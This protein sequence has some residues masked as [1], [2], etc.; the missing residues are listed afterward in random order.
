MKRF[1]PFLIDLYIVKKFLGTFFFALSL[2]I[3]IAVI[4]DF[5]EKID[6]FLEKQAPLK[7]IIVDYY[8]NFIPYF[9]VLF[10]SLFVFI[11]VLFFT[12]KMAGNSEIIAI[13]SS[14]V[15]LRRLLYPYFV[16]SVIIASLSYYLTNYVIP[17]NTYSRLLFEDVY[18]HSSPV[19]YSETNIHRQLQPGQFIYMEGFS[20]LSDIGRRFSIEQYR[21]DTL[22]SKINA[23]IVRWDSA[24]NKWTMLNYYRRDFISGKEKVTTGL[25]CD[26]TLN[27]HPR[28]FKQRENIIETMD[29]PRLDR[30]IENQKLQGSP[31]EWLLI[32]KH[33]RMAYPFSTIIL[34]VIAVCVSS[35]KVRGGIGMHMGLG[36]MISFSYILFMQFA[37]QFAIGGSI[38]PQ[39]A[40]WI[41]NLLYAAIALFLFYKTPQ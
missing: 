13:F 40:V 28:D 35:R 8:L 21:G 14:G 27:M 41:P 22:V 9:A 34:T 36:L 20:T 29:K 30:Y 17:H 19:Y 25:M 1:R 26:T 2:I 15:S 33:K 38:S 5:S 39:I 23:D 6:D 31:I 4:F 18:Y 16:S 12:S 11:S 32:E 24:K 10:S 7:A 3:C 37:A